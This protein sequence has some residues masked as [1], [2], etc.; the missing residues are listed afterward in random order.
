V[1]LRSSWAFRPGTGRDLPGTDRDPVLGLPNA[2]ITSTGSSE[3]LAPG[4]NRT[5]SFVSAWSTQP[6]TNHHRAGAAR[7]E[8]DLE[9]F[10]EQPDVHHD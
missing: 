3:K 7:S 5:S 1:E 4:L 2:S 9:Q 8:I 6:S 10:V